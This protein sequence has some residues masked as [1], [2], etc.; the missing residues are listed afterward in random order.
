[1]PALSLAGLPGRVLDFVLPPMC[2]ACRRPTAENG[3]LCGRCWGA[4]DFIERPFC[5]RL[6]IPLAYD[7]GDGDLLS[8][9]AIAHPPAYDRARAA[10]VFGEVAGDLVHAFKY[11]DRLETAAVM[12]RAMA[13][14]GA[15]LYA[16]ADAMI[17]VPLHR[18]RLFSRRY[19][20]A[21]ILA[22]T[23]SDISDKA[24]PVALSALK[25]ARATRHQVGLSVEARALNV[26][27]AF[28]VA[29][30]QHVRGKNLILVDDVLTSGATAAAAAMVLKRAGAGR[31]D[32][33]VFARVIAGTGEPI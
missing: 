5:D 24:P 23:I 13:R 8:P 28:V 29:E 11:R 22:R 9:E 16:N 15:D 18:S 33:L 2:P 10:V 19:N 21:A 6:G 7:I 26:T 30:P 14:A 12:A 32:V 3:A 17:P 20:Q 27:G 1:M 4:L 25:R 31:V